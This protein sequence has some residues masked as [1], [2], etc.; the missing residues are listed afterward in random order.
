MKEC[1]VWDIYSPV[2]QKADEKKIPLW[3]HMDLSYRCN[4]SCIH[5]YCQGLSQEF[6]CGQTELSITERK[7]LLDQLADAGGLYLGISGGE[8]MLHPDFFE[9]AW[10]AKKKNFCL[11][12]FTNGT[13]IDEK[14][15]YR[16]KELTP[17]IVALSIYGATADVHDAITRVTGSFDGTVRAI[18]LLKGLGLR[19]EL[20]SVIMELNHREIDNMEKL[21]HSLGAD[22]FSFNIEV[23]RKNDGSCEPHGYRMKEETMRSFMR[24]MLKGLSGAEDKYQKNPLDKP[25][26]ATGSLVCYIS[27]YGYIYPCILLLRPMGNIREK[28][29]AEIWH[30]RSDLRDELD[31]LKTYRDIPSCRSCKYVKPCRLC[32]GVAFSETGD[33]KKCYN[34]LRLISGIEYETVF[35]NKKGGD[36][37]KKDI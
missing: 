18:R 12:I 35:L 28:S 7:D 30:S 15:A 14:T 19:V 6:S 8:T 16:I 31:K 22:D 10:Y 33:M 27:P 4:L 32:L 5:C 34:T 37:G 25:L 3:V 36:H 2:L 13:L 29:F 23:S 24:G 26:C 11:S 21:T 17:R 9:I 20:R 1:E